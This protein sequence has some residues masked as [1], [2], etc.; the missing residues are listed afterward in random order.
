M[1]MTNKE[2]L[3]ELFKLC[4]EDE[5]LH[6][7]NSIKLSNYGSN[8]HLV[9][10]EGEQKYKVLKSVSWF[11]IITYDSNVSSTLI[12]KLVK[13]NNL[14]QSHEFLEETYNDLK[15]LVSSNSIIVHFDDL[16]DLILSLKSKTSTTSEEPKTY[17]VKTFLFFKR[18]FNYR[19]KTTVHNYYFKLIHGTI[20]ENL[21]LEEGLNFF[22]AYN[23]SLKKKDLNKLNER[24]SNYKSKSE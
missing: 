15:V 5:N 1:E 23:E 19:K 6:S 17:E 8:P 12:D 20:Q 21:S 11:D 22:K 14:N 24:I 18:R 10:D 2:K 9:Y 16:P 13:Q 7:S 3:I 4:I